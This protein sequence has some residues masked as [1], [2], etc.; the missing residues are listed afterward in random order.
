MKTRGIYI[1]TNLVNGKKYV[2]KD[3]ALPTRVS[4][5]LAGT[6]V[7]CKLIHNAIKKYGRENFDI[8]IIPYPNISK[9]ALNAVEQWK[10]ASLQT[11]VPNGYNLTDGGDG[12]PGC[13]PSPEK[14]RKI[15]ASRKGY[16]HSE[17][18]RR[19]IGIASAKRSEK[20]NQQISETLKARYQDGMQPW[21]K[22]KKGSQT[23]WIKGKKQSPETRKKLSEASKRL[24]ADPE[25]RA[26]HTGENHHSKRRK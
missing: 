13:K 2:G 16:T 6:A 1:L 12:T 21:N 22:D 7:T 3:A 10:I 23:S 9:D 15:V 5:H 8:E 20:I 11:K 14:I 26:K 17:E 4:Q 25:F 18:T 19:K 24:W